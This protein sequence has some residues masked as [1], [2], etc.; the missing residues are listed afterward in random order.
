MTEHTRQRTT[1]VAATTVR[2]CPNGV[3]D[4]VLLDL[5][6]EEARL[7]GLPPGQPVHVDRQRNPATGDLVWAELVR[8][9]T[10]Q[11]MVRRYGQ[12]AGWVTLSAS[13]GG[14]AAIM[15]RQAELLILG[16]VDDSTGCI[17]STTA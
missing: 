10:T 16:V 5:S 6:D 2:P 8:R 14:A 1:R 13:G 9:G 7:A 17:V 11:R 15:R 3:S 12:D 4:H